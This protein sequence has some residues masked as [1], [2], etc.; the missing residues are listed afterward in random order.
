MPGF[1]SGSIFPRMFVIVALSSLFFGIDKHDSE[2]SSQ[3]KEKREGLLHSIDSL[4]SEFQSDSKVS[5]QYQSLFNVLQDL[6]LKIAG[7]DD[8]DLRQYAFGFFRTVTDDFELEKSD[9]GQ[10]LL[11]LSRSLGNAR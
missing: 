5:P 7:G 10:R 6:R 8:V 4:L 11:E 1:V 2:E 3:E 9:F